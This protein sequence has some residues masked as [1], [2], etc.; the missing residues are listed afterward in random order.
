MS[1]EGQICAGPVGALP[2]TEGGTD[3]SW[4][5]LCC[6]LIATPPHTLQGVRLGDLQSMKRAPDGERLEACQSGRSAW[7]DTG[8]L[9]V[10]YDPGYYYDP[11]LRSSPSIVT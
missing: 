6:E 9:G 8:Q 11:C 7:G 4:G 2:L 5:T 3:G 1:S 10:D